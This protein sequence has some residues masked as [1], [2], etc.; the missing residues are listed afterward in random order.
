MRHHH[1]RELVRHA[2]VIRFDRVVAVLQTGA[3]QEGALIDALAT[4]GMPACDPNDFGA[5]VPRDGK[6]RIG[7]RAEVAEVRPVC[8]LDLVRSLYVRI[9]LPALADD[10]DVFEARRG[11]SAAVGDARKDT[12][13]PR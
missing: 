11:R 7:E 8:D 10:R 4:A 6:R 13:G 9:V 12:C 5:E 1:R 3:E 2:G